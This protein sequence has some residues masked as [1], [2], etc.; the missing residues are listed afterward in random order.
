M[1]EHDSELLQRQ[2]VGSKRDGRRRYDKQAKA[3]L[4]QACLKPGVSVARVALEHG[5]NA[6][7]LR[8][9]ITL[10]LQ[11]QEQPAIATSQSVAPSPSPFVPVVPAGS[12]GRR[13]ES[14]LRV[15]LPNGIEISLRGHDED[16]LSSL[17]RLLCTLP[18]SASTQT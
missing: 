6:N 17:L 11:K 10:H 1:T 3:E 13:T 14:G 12:C 4:V 18:C 15:R 16:A 8:K 5:V 7:L 2:V 9:W